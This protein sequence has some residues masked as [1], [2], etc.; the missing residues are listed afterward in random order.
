MATVV[1][2]SLPFR[3]SE[4]K[5]VD[6]SDYKKIWD[7]RVRTVLLTTKFERV[8]RPTFGAEVKSALMEN[9]SGLDSAEKTVADTVSEAFSAWLLPLTVKK[10]TSTFRFQE[11]TMNVLV[12]YQLPN[13][14]EVSTA[15]NSLTISGDSPPQVTSSTT[16]DADTGDK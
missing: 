2:V 12:T 15:V 4:G 1:T 11:G 9:S 13:K 16:T 5:V 10:V 3:V 7:D 6:T 14:E 8:N